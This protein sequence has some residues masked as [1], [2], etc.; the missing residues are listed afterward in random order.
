MAEEERYLEQA[1]WRGDI[2]TVG[3]RTEERQEVNQAKVSHIHGI[4]REKNVM[5]DM[6]NL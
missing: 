3:L 4:C 5:S 2:V 1:P 6:T